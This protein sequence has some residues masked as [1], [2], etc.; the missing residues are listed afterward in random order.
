VID[1]ST[2]L[3]LGAGGASDGNK[4]RVWKIKYL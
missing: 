2:G 3:P 1:P 4:G